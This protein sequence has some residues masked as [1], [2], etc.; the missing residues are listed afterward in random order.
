M[1]SLLKR[2]DGGSFTTTERFFLHYFHFRQILPVD[3]LGGEERFELFARALS[4][5]CAEMLPNDAAH[6]PTI[7]KV[8]EE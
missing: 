1:T 3:G 4:I 8:I 2:E 6:I 7:S 5:L